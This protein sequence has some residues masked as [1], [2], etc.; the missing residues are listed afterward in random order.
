MYSTQIFFEH[1]TPEQLSGCPCLIFE[2]EKSRTFR[3]LLSTTN[4]LIIYTFPLPSLFSRDTEPHRRIAAITKKAPI[5]S[6]LYLSLSKT[7]DNAYDLNQLIKTDH[8]WITLHRD[9]TTKITLNWSHRRA[10]KSYKQRSLFTRCER[11][12]VGL[13]ETERERE[14]ENLQWFKSHSIS[15]CV[16]GLHFPIGYLSLQYFIYCH[17][18]SFQ[19]VLFFIIYVGIEQNFFLMCFVF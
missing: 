17:S 11:T 19:I 7:R 5:Q 14:R 2:M 10:A 13:R 9:W 4:T 3:G 12:I 15:A 1:D 8:D 18:W 16:V 6:L